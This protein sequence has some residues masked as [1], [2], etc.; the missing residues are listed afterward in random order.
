MS[1]AGWTAFDSVRKCIHSYHYVH[2]DYYYHKGERVNVSGGNG[3]FLGMG[4]GVENWD[5]VFVS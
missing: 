1:V 2:C 5:D 4:M 3:L